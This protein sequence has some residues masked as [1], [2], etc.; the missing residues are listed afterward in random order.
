MLS[1]LLAISK[2]QAGAAATAVA[3]RMPLW[4]SQAYCWLVASLAA[5]HSSALCTNA[6]A[7][8]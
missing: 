3:S 6:T 4:P 2:R 5:S 8:S 7:S 1:N